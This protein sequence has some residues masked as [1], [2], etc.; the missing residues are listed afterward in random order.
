MRIKSDVDLKTFCNL[1]YMIFQIAAAAGLSH[2]LWVWGG[3][4]AV[5]VRVWEVLIT[6]KVSWGP[7]ISSALQVSSQSIT[8]AALDKRGVFSGIGL[9][10]LTP[11]EGAPI[12][13]VISLCLIT[14]PLQGG[15]HCPRSI[16]C[17]K[18]GNPTWPFDPL[19]D[20]QSFHSL[21]V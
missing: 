9:G 13:R 18:H 20:P 2:S 5:S 15:G 7:G 21:P 19:G 11:W 8:R 1:E 6:V 10:P 17:L 3:S 14:E 16:L 4:S 12:I